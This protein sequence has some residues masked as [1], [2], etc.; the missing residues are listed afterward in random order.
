MLMAGGDSTS[1][2]N[3]LCFLQAI[4]KP[5]VLAGMAEASHELL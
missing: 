3:A 5:E 1:Y 2:P 4:G